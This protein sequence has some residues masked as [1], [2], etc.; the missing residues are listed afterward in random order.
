MAVDNGDGPGGRVIAEGQ[1]GSVPEGVQ[2]NGGRLGIGSG[3]PRKVAGSG[4]SGGRVLDEGVGK[5]A[6][7]SRG[8]LR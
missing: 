3:A 6:A 7:G 5:R 8:S 4:R 2:G 1:V